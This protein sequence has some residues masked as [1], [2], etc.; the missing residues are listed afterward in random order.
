MPEAH[1]LALLQKID[2]FRNA[3]KGRDKQGTVAMAGLDGAKRA[4]SR[5]IVWMN[6]AFMS[7]LAVSMSWVN[8]NVSSAV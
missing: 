1:D 4:K 6:M 3:V 7:G 5:L 8:L 2:E